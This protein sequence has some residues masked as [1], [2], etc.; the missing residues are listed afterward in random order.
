MCAALKRNLFVRT[1]S[2]YVLGRSMNKA[3]PQLLAL[4]SYG[5]HEMENEHRC[6][7]E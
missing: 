3:I 7:V 6:Q 5:L 4:V 1:P 2:H